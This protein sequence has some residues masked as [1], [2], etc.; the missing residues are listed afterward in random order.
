MRVIGTGIAAILAASVGT[1]SHEMRGPVAGGA[2]AGASTAMRVV[3]SSGIVRRYRLHVPPGAPVGAP[4][5]LVV[6]FHGAGSTTAQQERASGLSELADRERFVVA[7]PE[8]RDRQWTADV[9]DARFVR[10]LVADVAAQR[11]IDARRV[12]ATG[13]SSGAAMAERAVCELPDLFAALATVAGAFDAAGG[14]RTGRSVP[15][16]AFHGRADVVVPFVGRTGARPLASAVSWAAGWA[17]RDGCLPTPAVVVRTPG[18]ATWMWGGCPGGADVVLEV[19]DDL[20]HAWPG[21]PTDRRGAS[22]I[23]ATAEIWDFFVTHPAR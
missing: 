14:C 1:G 7:Y 2:R 12:Y 22:P 17:A 15:V 23:D 6:A 19:V 18:V 16:L 4:L 13:I 21:D 11:P 20:G 10:D 8:G 9:R 3:T 5:P